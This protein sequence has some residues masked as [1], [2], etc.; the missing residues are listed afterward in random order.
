[1][2][3]RQ[4]L[5]LTGTASVAAL[6]L[7]PTGSARAAG[8]GSGRDYYE[9]RQFIL[10]TEAQ[11]Q[12][13]DAFLKEAAIPA[14]NR[15]GLKPVGVFRPAEGLSPVYVLLRHK[16]L[17]TVVN[18]NAELAADPD[19]LSNGEEFINAPAEAPAFKRMESSLM[20]AFEGMPQLERPVSNPG[21]VFQLRIYESPSVRTGLKKIEMFNDAGEIR[22]FR[23]VGLNPVFF[24]QTVVGTRMPNLTYMLA[25]KNMEEQKAAWK[26]FVSHPEWKR[27]SAMPEYSDKAILSGITNLQLVAAEYS[28]I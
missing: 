20:V 16:S 21:R 5:A 14:L 22:L 1:M 27:L 4:F 8:G 18:L 3:R 7:S 11:K 17:D 10:E 24:G 13:L 19:F 26:K 6:T 28:Q 25:F 23:E 9:L 15:L 12:K 2:K